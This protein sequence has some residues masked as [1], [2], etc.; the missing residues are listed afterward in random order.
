MYY[1]VLYVQNCTRFSLRSKPRWM[2]KTLVDRLHIVFLNFVFLLFAFSV[3][4][5]DALWSEESC[6]HKSSMTSA[7]WKKYTS[8]DFQFIVSDK[9]DPLWSIDVNTWKECKGISRT[10]RLP[11]VNFDT[12]GF[13]QLTC[14]RDT[15]KIQT[16]S[17]CSQL[18]SRVILLNYSPSP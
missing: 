14:K 2:M 15:T 12:C 5:C 13:M 3:L 1:S 18:L 10:K 16:K 11:A 4:F 8:L 7:T 9:S 17:S 6:G